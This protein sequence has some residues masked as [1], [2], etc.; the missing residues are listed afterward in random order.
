MLGAND[1]IVSTSSLVL[2]VAAAGADHRTVLLTSVSGLI[3]G[4]MSMAAGEFVSVHLQKDAENADPVCERAE[5]KADPVGEQRELAIIYMERGLEKPL[6][7]QVAG[8]LMAHDAIGAHTRD[9]L[10]FSPATEARP[11]Q[12]ALAL[13][14]SFAV[15]R[16][17]AHWRGVDRHARSAE[18]VGLGGI[19]GLSGGPGRH[20]SAGRLRTDGQGRLT[21]DV[22]GRRGD[23]CHGG[24]WRVLRSGCLSGL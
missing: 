15:G 24:S 11:T 17:A 4:A 13:A 19:A 21:H 6:A 12:A 18:P 23:G 1:G 2:G 22:L 5:L 9:E 20:I 14:A 8:K 16:C 7:E 10:G 3:A